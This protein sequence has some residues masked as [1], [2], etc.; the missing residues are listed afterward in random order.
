MSLQTE[1][2]TSGKFFKVYVRID[3]LD[4]GKFIRNVSQYINAKNLYLPNSLKNSRVLI[5]S[6]K[7]LQGLYIYNESFCFNTS[8]KI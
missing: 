1:E 4:K 6:I 3:K 5:L 7:K 8:P 2:K